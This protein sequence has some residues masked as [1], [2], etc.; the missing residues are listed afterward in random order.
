MTRR[1]RAIFLSDIHLGTRGC[2]AERLLDFLRD[3]E[4]EYL[5][6]VGDIID[7]WVMNRGIQWS[8][9][10]NTVVQKLLRRAR[11]GEKIFLI[12]GNHDEAL[13]EYLDMNFGGIQVVGEY[14]HAAADGRRYLLIHGDEFDQVTRHHRWVAMLGDIAYNG[15]VRINAWLSW[16]RR[17]FNRPGYWSLAGYAK[18]KVKTAVSFIFDFEDSVIRA[19]RERGVDGVICGHIHSA[20]IR[21]ANGI[22]YLNCGDWVD[23]CTAIVEHLDGR[24]ELIHYHAAAPQHLP[25]AVIAPS[26][27]PPSRSPRPRPREVESAIAAVADSAIR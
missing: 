18:R 15:L 23:S 16:L 22:T 1:V 11:H 10:Q 9:A 2:Q 20:T 6:L 8:A 12:P 25:Q 7:F 4:A 3:H 13:R 14:I 19:A 5:F 17:R 24:M 26:R 27:E 21:E